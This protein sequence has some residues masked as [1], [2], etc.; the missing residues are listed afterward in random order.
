MEVPVQGIGTRIRDRRKALKMT[1]RHLA[2]AIGVGSD[3]VSKHERGEMGVSA[4][5]L[6]AYAKALETTAEFLAGDAEPGSSRPGPK[7]ALRV[8]PR[9]ARAVPM[10]LAQLLN[11]GRC[12]PITDDEMAHLSRH[13]DDGNSTELADLEIHLLAH[14]AERDRT[15]DAVQAFRNAVRRARGLAPKPTTKRLPAKSH[16]KKPVTV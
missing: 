2:E 5:T 4:D 16:A 11:D 1:Q 14:R 3:T 7:P 8:V 13:L 10:A 9:S 15:E 12:N 6:F